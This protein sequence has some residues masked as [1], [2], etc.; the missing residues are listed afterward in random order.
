MKK[1]FLAAALLV[2]LGAQAQTPNTVSNPMTGH[3]YEFRAFGIVDSAV[4]FG[5]MDTTWKPRRD[6]ALIYDS[7]ANKFMVWRSGAWS[8]VGDTGGGSGI[9][10]SPTQTVIYNNNFGTVR[11][12]GFLEM[13]DGW[14]PGAQFGSPTFDLNYDTTGNQVEFLISANGTNSVSMNMSELKPDSSGTNDVYDLFPGEQDIYSTSQT[15][16]GMSSNNFW[17]VSDGNGITYSS[18]PGNDNEQQLFRVDPH[19]GMRNSRLNDA[20]TG[21]LQMFSQNSDGSFNMQANNG[22]TTQNLFT[23]QNNGNFSFI[24]PYSDFSGNTTAY[25]FNGSEFDWEHTNDAGNGNLNLAGMS[26]YGFWGY[27]DDGT[28]TTNSYQF[29]QGNTGFTGSNDGYSFYQFSNGQTTISSDQ[30]GSELQTFYLDDRGNLQLDPNDGSGTGGGSHTTFLFNSS[31]NEY[32]QYAVTS[33]YANQYAVFDM[34]A[35]SG[36]TV[37]GWDG[38]TNSQQ[39]YQQQNNGAYSYYTPSSDWS[40][41]LPLNYVDN[42]G[43]ALWYGNDGTTANSIFDIQNNGQFYDICYNS[44][45]SNFNAFEIESGNGGAYMQMGNGTDYSNEIWQ[46]DQGGLYINY[47]NQN[48]ATNSAPE[49]LDFYSSGFYFNAPSTDGTSSSNDFSISNTDGTVQPYYSN[50]GNNWYAFNRFDATFTLGQFDTYNYATNITNLYGDEQGGFV[51][52]AVNGYKNTQNIDYVATA[53]SFVIYTPIEFNDIG[54]LVAQP[55]ALYIGY[56]PGEGEYFGTYRDSVMLMLGNSLGVKGQTIYSG[57]TDRSL[58]WGDATVSP[59]IKGS[60]ATSPFE[61]LWELNQEGSDTSNFLRLGQNGGFSFGQYFSDSYD[62]IYKDS[63]TDVLNIIGG[64]SGGMDLQYGALFVHP[65]S[66]N[67]SLLINTDPAKYLT[68]N[69][70]GKLYLKTVTSSTPNLTQVMAGTGNNVATTYLFMTDGGDPTHPWIVEGVQAGS[71][72]GYANFIDSATRNRTGIFPDEIDLYQGGS[73]FTTSIYPTYPGTNSNN[74]FLPDES[75]TAIVDNDSTAKYATPTQVRTAIATAAVNGVYTPTLT[76][77]TN[78]SASTPNQFTYSRVGNVVTYAGSI[79]VTTS[80]A[81]A[82]EVD[83]S[84]PIASAFSSDNDMNGTGQSK[85]V[86]VNVI[87][88]GDAVNDRGECEFTGVSI[89]GTGTIFVSGQYIVR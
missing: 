28:N 61:Q 4:F 85:T 2:G 74:F 27:T 68:T 45:G 18:N 38:G 77:V 21:S 55:E 24:A 14:N 88:E 59:W 73:G 22:S 48:G 31:N 36:L 58:Y 41:N 46:M 34:T 67:S 30:G 51:G 56:I 76:N 26:N 72:T 23:D 17:Q 3:M 35:G 64:V 1:I 32:T 42:G 83:F 6:K 8:P 47:F 86:A 20:N 40:T 71:G 87:N 57:G 33:D 49:M 12:W 5:N 60:L 70:D 9:G 75:G 63:T 19:S 79:T 69:A 29:Y 11:G 84:L 80:L 50:D 10:Y 13:I 78:V 52:Q 66:I 89:S 7:V 53:D 81:A 39:I 65:D 62:K 43:N 37:S 82:S 25:S 54:A 15:D 16:G 44:N